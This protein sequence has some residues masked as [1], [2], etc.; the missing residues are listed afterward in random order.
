MSFIQKRKDDYK[1][2]ERLDDLE[3]IRRYIK[4]L[5]AKIVE[6]SKVVENLV[7]EVMYIKAELRK[8]ERKE[9][10]EKSTK[11]EVKEESKDKVDSDSD[12]DIIIV[13]QA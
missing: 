12:D 10:S 11:L 3:G 13:D 9:G 2:V 1:M 4:E 6:L 5:E 8:S 7:S